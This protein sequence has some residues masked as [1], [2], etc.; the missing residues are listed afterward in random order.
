ML[1]IYDSFIDKRSLLWGTI[2]YE[3]NPLGNNSVA[4]T[5]ISNPH[6]TPRII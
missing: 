2:E 4:I 5:V 1:L 3:I 6:L